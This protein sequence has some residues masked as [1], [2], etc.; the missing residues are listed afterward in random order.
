MI[1]STGEPLHLCVPLGPACECPVKGLSGCRR[2]GTRGLLSSKAILEYQK[3][4]HVRS[5]LTI[6]Y[7]FSDTFHCEC[8]YSNFFAFLRTSLREKTK[9]K[10]ELSSWVFESF[11]SSDASERQVIKCDQHNTVLAYN[12]STRHKLDRLNLWVLRYH[13]VYTYPHFKETE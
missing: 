1:K 11:P 12:I 9:T 13:S 7:I 2:S 6:S 5:S 3:T 10:T 8:F 4:F